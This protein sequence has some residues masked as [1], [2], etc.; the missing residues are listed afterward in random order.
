MGTFRNILRSRFLW[1]LI[2][3]VASGVIA[4]LMLDIPK[5][6][7][8]VHRGIGTVGEVTSKDAEE[9][10]AI[11][12]TYVVEGKKYT[13]GGYSGDINRDFDDIKVG[14]P[15]QCVYDPLKPSSSTLGDPNPQLNSLV[16]GGIFFTSFPT[17]LWLCYKAERAIKRRREA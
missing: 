14:D 5:Y 8:L 2:L 6:Y 9:H 3:T 4:L 13:W 16:H 17:I 1:W 12:Y 11:H 7:Q 15:V 10:R